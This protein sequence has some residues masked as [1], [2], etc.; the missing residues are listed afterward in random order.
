MPADSPYRCSYWFRTEFTTPPAL[1]GKTA[2]LHFLGINYRAN[3]WL[4]GKK[5]ADRTEVAGAY[6][7]YEFRINGLLKESGKN[8]L[9]VEVFAPEKN[10][11]GLTWVDWNP[12]PPDKD[13]G[14][15]REVFLSGSGEVALRNPF[16]RSKLGAD[17][18]SAELTLSAELRNTTD[19]PVNAVLV[20][21]FDNTHL[22]QPVA[23]A[24]DETKVVH[25]SPE[26]YAQL[27]LPHPRL[28]WPYQMGEP[29]LYTARFRVE[30]GK[31]ISD[32]ASINFGIREV[33]SELTDKG[34]RLFKINGRN[35]L[36]RGG[37]DFFG[38]GCPVFPLL[39][40]VATD[41]A[42]HNEN[43]KTIG[44]FEKF[45]AVGL[46]FETDCI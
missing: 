10:D 34:Y 29:Y 1:A 11:L 8:A 24:A 13:M 22:S 37:G 4:N 46:A 39:P 26:Q 38:F 19:H 42:R 45:V 16:V 33:T 21:D 41:P 3:V 25:F 2:W 5:I 44:L 43:A 14:I 28:W 6:R 12:T 36:I 17:Y 15:W 32:A 40:G 20:A 18:K 23:L 7:S 30:T 27:K 9:A 35:V 31:D